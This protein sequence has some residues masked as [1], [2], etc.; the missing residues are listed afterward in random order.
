ML[1]GLQRSSALIGI[2]NLLLEILG[3][4]GDATTIT[5]IKAN[6]EAEFSG[7]LTTSPYKSQY[8][9]FASLNC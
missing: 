9:S 6:A 4:Y 8:A 3:V 2:L 1:V 7:G 5:R